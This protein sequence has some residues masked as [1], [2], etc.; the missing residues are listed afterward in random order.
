M[1]LRS[2]MRSIERAILALPE[3]VRLIVA[4]NTFLSRVGQDELR[5]PIPKAIQENLES[6]HGSELRT[7][8]AEL[9]DVSV[10]VLISYGLLGLAYSLTIN[11]VSNRRTMYGQF[12]TPIWLADILIDILARQQR[13]VRPCR[14][15]AL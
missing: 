7:L 3:P 15:V 14:Q 1:T 11:S 6:T 12:F 4:C 2:F 5:L 10:S 13:M 8:T 9:D